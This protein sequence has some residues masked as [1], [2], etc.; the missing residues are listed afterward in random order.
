MRN[1][2]SLFLLILGFTFCNVINSAPI[3]IDSRIISYQ[4]VNNLITVSIIFDITFGFFKLD[5]GSVNLPKF[6]L[7]LV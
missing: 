4:I 2:D 5:F 3:A 1:V 7:K 6:I